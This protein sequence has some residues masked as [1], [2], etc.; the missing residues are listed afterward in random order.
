MWRSILSKVISHLQH[1]GNA[2]L[3]YDVILRGYQFHM[4]RTN[5]VN[6]HIMMYTWHNALNPA[7]SQTKQHNEVIII[8]ELDTTCLYNQLL[9]V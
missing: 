6:L 5:T 9:A 4:S 7:I 8:L 3:A 2:H 1:P